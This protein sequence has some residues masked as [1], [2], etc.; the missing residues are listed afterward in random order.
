MGIVFDQSLNTTDSPSFVDG[1]F[2]GTVTADTIQSTSTAYVTPPQVYF[3]G[4][5]GFL[6]G[7][8]TNT[9][10]RWTDSS[11]QIRQ[12]MTPKANGTLTCGT[13]AFRWS[14][15][16]S[17]DGNFSGVVTSPSNLTLQSNSANA[18]LSVADSGAISITAYNSIYQQFTTLGVGYREDCYPIFD[19]S[20]DLG[21]ST[22]RWANVYSVDG[23]FTG[24]LVSEVGGTQRLYGLGTEGDV[25]T[26]YVETGYVFGKP[27]IQSL[28]TGTGV[29]KD[30]L[31]GNP[32]GARLEVRPNSDQAFVYGGSGSSIIG[33]TILWSVV[34]WKHCLPSV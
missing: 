20:L 16:A 26:E 29:A 33:V 8:N 11:V 17:V 25:D 19:G 27:T 21:L 14:T 5:G 23:S 18:K 6:A 9:A 1:N 7:S 2:S 15:V 31:V 32:A 10:L 4:S 34:Y 28:A 3:S 30:L 24:N 22:N 13:D 12:D